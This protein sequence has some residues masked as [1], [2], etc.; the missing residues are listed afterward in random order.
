MLIREALEPWWH[1]LRAQGVSD[2]TLRAYKHDVSQFLEYL[3]LTDLASFEACDFNMLQPW[4]LKPRHPRT[5]ARALASLRHFIHYLGWKQH[6]LLY[7]KG[8]KKP[9][10][11]PRAL[12]HEHVRILRSQLNENAATSWIGQRD[13]ALFM[14]IYSVGMRISE[15]LGLKWENI[16][17]TSIQFIGKRSKKREVPLLPFVSQLLNDYR[18]ACPYKEVND[19][20]IGVRGGRLALSVADKTMQTLRQNLGLPETLTPH[21]L[22]HTCATHLL[23]SSG[24]LRLIQELLGHES[25]A[26][27]Q[28]YTHVCRDHIWKSYTSFHP[29]AIKKST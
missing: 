6:P 19:V 15:A 7:I 27:T 17:N 29:R 28:V 24:E 22:R 1:H 12:T 20:F 21:A 16:S 3:N 2:H 14:L 10:T 18:K 13:H 26:S 23:E 8:P 9:Q 11:L 4:L 25:L 5:T